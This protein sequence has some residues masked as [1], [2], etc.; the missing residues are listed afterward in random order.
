MNAQ[1]IVLFVYLSDGFMLYVLQETSSV[2]HKLSV[3]M[4][5]TVLTGYRWGLVGIVIRYLAPCSDH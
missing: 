1:F 2:R 5:K 3:A 4:P